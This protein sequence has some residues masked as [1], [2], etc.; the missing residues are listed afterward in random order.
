METDEEGLHSAFI[1]LRWAPR[2][3]EGTAEQRGSAGSERLCRAPL[4]ARGGLTEGRRGALSFLG[5][6]EFA[7]RS[8]SSQADSC[9]SARKV[10][11]SQHM[12]I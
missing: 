3:E 5:I 11:L 6:G 12:R 8:L 10:K 2:Q 4:P 1:W 7:L 9:L